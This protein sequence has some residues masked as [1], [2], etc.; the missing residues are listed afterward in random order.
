MGAYI[1]PNILDKN[2]IIACSK[3]LQNAEI[4][5]QD[6]SN[7][8]PK[9]KD[10]VYIDP[11]YQPINHTSF[12][13]YTKLDFTEADQI[14]LYENAENYIRTVYILCSNSDNDFIKNL[15]KSFS[16]DIVKAPRS[17]NCKSTVG[18]E[19]MKF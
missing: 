3:A 1:N 6:F 2:N 4:I 15:Y 12:T 10:F 19:L 5:Y 17:I 16:I 18:K 9:P 14:K 13:K 8:S 11:P 7:I